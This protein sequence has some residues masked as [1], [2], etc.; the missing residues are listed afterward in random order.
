MCRS[1]VVFITV[2]L[3]GCG[4][5][6]AGDADLKAEN[7]RLREE[8]KTLKQRLDEVSGAPTSDSVVM[9]GTEV[10]R[11]KAE[12]NGQDYEIRIKFPREYDP[13]HE[14][15]PVLYVIDAETNFGGVSYI[16][17][18]LVK[19]DL[20]PK[21]LVVGIAY[22][23]EYSEFYRLRS[24]DLTP[25]RDRDL[26]SGG[27]SEPDP[28]GGADA[29]S[30]FL[31]HELFPFVDDNYP[32]KKGDRAIYGH[33]YGG[34]YGCHVLLTRP[35]MFN[36][37]LLLSPS[38]WYDDSLLLKR[39]ARA[40]L[41][42]GSTRLYVGSGELEPRIDEL[43]VRFVDSLRARRPEG[44]SIESEVLANETHRTIFGAGFT[45]GMRFIFGAGMN[46]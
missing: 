10:R 43:Q 1:V 29:F 30:D 25:T 15:Y 28:A 3:A 34:L 8:V 4:V 44:L 9:S 16:V 22:D 14:V 39:V 33:S 46:G 24:R 17:Q 31:E 42:F 41:E 35:R 21:I 20:I 12:S 27:A 6:N 2:M 40:P 13:D 19:D 11:L 26:R 36:R 5:S 38:L 32:A 18:R 37:Y 45:N 7:E 23:T